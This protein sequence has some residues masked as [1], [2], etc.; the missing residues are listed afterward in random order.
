MRK[1]LI[2]TMFIIIIMFVGC[3]KS[4]AETPTKDLDKD[5]I[6]NK[7]Q[8]IEELLKKIGGGLPKSSLQLFEAEIM[9]LKKNKIKLS[10]YKGKVIFLNLWATW[11]PPCRAEMP[12]MESLYKKF[13][14]KDFVIIA[15]SQGED[16]NTIKNFLKKNNYTF[17]IFIDIKNE[18]AKSYGAGSIPTSYLIDKDGFIIAR[19]VG[20]RDWFSDEAIELINELVKDSPGV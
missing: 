14:D 1:R 7:K 10:S 11:C 15:V 2:I 19:F 6:K 12:S 13:K 4:N 5:K 18:I 17:P 20:G 9:D 3:K 8:V 16:L